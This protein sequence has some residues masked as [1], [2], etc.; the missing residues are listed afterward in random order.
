MTNDKNDTTISIET[1]TYNK[2]HSLTGHAK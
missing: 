2:P 1:G